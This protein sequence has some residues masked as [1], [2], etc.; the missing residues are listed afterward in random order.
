[1]ATVIQS[2]LCARNGLMSVS[3]QLAKLEQVSQV[4]GAAPLWLLWLSTYAAESR[5]AHLRLLVRRCRGPVLNCSHCKQANPQKIKAEA[6]TEIQGGVVTCTRRRG[7][8]DRS[9]SVP[10]ALPAHCPG[11]LQNHP[12]VPF[13]GEASLGYC[14]LQNNVGIL[15]KASVKII[16]TTLRPIRSSVSVLKS[17]EKLFWV[18]LLCMYYT[19]NLW[20]SPTADD[21]VPLFLSPASYQKALS[22]SKASLMTISGLSSSHKLAVK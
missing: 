20:I 10:C 19:C 13:S 9:S 22:V 8:A 21:S 17:S 6:K 2:H 12:L 4:T 18:Y 16:W 14:M 3:K 5:G 15:G 1:M 11:S 7:R